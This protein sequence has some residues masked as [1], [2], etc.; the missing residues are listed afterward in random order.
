MTA[1]ELTVAQRCQSS[2]EVQ[3]SSITTHEESGAPIRS[4]S[5]NSSCELDA[6]PKISKI[7]SVIRFSRFNDICFVLFV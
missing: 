1:Q 4:L 6:E 2:H 5:I 3:L 7:L